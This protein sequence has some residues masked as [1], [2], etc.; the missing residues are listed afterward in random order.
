MRH[1]NPT[2]QSG[3]T[4]VEIAI[5]LVIIGLLLGGVLK[6][7]ELIENSK[8]KRGV[9]EING[10]SAAY[11]TYI[12]RFN[13]V[14]GDDGGTAR[15]RTRGDN[16]ANVDRSGD[17]NGMLTANRNTTWAPTGEAEAFWQ[18]L[19]AAG[20]ITGEVGLRGAQAL[21][22]NAFGGLIAVV[23][24]PV[25]GGLQGLKVCLSQVPGKSARAIDTQMD[26]GLGA[27]GKTRATQGNGNR[28][29]NNSAL[30][31]E[32]SDDLSYTVCTQV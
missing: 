5:V 30:A 31:T 18:H 26:D 15:L 2:K 1:K 8:V 10:I 23:S 22:R 9:N 17:S 11:Y 27:S 14:P 4:L 21:P 19:R 13:R 12:D 20:F 25:N 3:F 28:N 7:T 29:P 24:Q 6:G 16:W 32:Y